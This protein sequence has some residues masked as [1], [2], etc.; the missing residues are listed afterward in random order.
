MAK[1]KVDAVTVRVRFPAAAFAR[2]ERLAG[3]LDMDVPT[4]VR[5]LA[6]LQLIQL[7]TTT[8]NA[9]LMVGKTPQE[10]EAHMD[11]QAVEMFPEGALVG[12]GV[13]L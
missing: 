2:V 10:V 1:R 12:S 4:V 7:E 5:T 3:L 9:A 13:E 8:V 11:S 6:S